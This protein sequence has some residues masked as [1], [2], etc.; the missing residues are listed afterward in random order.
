MENTGGGMVGNRGEGN[1][2]TGSAGTWT[3]VTVGEPRL[4]DMVSVR[5]ATGARWEAAANVG[6]FADSG[7]GGKADPAAFLQGV[8]TSTRW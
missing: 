4:I 3:R 6:L 8:P 7:G 1:A 2:W 5:L